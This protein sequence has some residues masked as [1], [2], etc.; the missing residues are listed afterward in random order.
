MLGVPGGGGTGAAGPSGPTG[1]SGSTGST[2]STGPSGP[3][4]QQG[5]PGQLGGGGGCCD[6]ALANS[7]HHGDL[8]ESPESSGRPMPGRM[9]WLQ[10]TGTVT[11][12]AG[13]DTG[14]LYLGCLNGSPPTRVAYCGTGTSAGNYTFA[15]VAGSTCTPGSPPTDGTFWQ[16]GSV[17]VTAGVFGTP[18]SQGGT[19]YVGSDV[20]DPASH[21][22]GTAL[23]VA[24]FPLPRRG[25]APPEWQTLVI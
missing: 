19:A 24:T 17:P 16:M 3:P 10:R 7:N 18:T 25:W 21:N 8:G 9:C 1:P 15:N 14:T 6:L 11:F 22:G 5:R 23:S 2:G 13:T 4:A 20:R 12:A